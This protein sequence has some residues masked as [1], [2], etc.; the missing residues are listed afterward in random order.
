[1]VSFFFNKDSFLKIPKIFILTVPGT[2]NIVW[3]CYDDGQPGVAGNVAFQ[4]NGVG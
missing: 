4:E 2:N 3:H 1:M